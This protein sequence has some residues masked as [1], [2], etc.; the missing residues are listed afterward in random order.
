MGQCWLSLSLSAS[1]RFELL[2]FK[3]LVCYVILLKLVLRVL[4]LMEANIPI[5][6]VPKGIHIFCI[7]LNSITKSFNFKMSLIL[8][9]YPP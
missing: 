3:Y 1:V 6:C 5:T 2:V 9:Y 8:L 4:H 7:F